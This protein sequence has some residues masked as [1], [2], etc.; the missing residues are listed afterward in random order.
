MKAYLIRWTGLA[1]MVAVFAGCASPSPKPAV[2]YVDPATA[3]TLGGTGLESQ[4]IVAAANKAA[5]SI[6]NLPQ[7]AQ[8]PTPP[9]VLITPVVN[10]SA[11]P[12]DTDLYTTKLRGILMSYAPDKVRFLARDVGFETSKREE[13]LRAQGEVRA[14]RPR[15]AH[16]YDYILTAEV[17]GIS[18]A[19]GGA[20]SE[21]YL[22]AFKLVDYD[23][24]LVWENQY[25]VKKEGRP[26]RVYR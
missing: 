7:I 6:V 8:A 10:R 23:D 5:A 2:R 14:G 13:Q 9:I 22:V 16:T 4:D 24:L 1:A 20:Q 3:G 21:Y 11:A 19:G 15:S 26:H 12:V 17:R 18:A 25:E